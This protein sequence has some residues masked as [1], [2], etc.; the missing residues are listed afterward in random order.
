MCYSRA[1]FKGILCQRITLSRSISKS[2]PSSSVISRQQKRQPK[3]GL[4]LT[5]INKSV[6][7]FSI[8]ASHCDL[9]KKE[10]VLGKRKSKLALFIFVSILKADLK[11]ATINCKKVKAQNLLTGK[12]VFHRKKSGSLN[13]CDSSSSNI[14]LWC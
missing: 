7:D 9:Y 11:F 5:H 2:P 6:I 3:S 14:I 13:I 12:L 1:F 4:E 10:R 8:F